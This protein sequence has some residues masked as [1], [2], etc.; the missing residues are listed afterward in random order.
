MARL[1]RRV[2]GED[3]A[4]AGLLQGVLQCKPV[5]IDVAANDSSPVDSDPWGWKWIAADTTYKLGNGTNP[6]SGT[7]CVMD[8]NVELSGD[9]GAD[10]APLD[11]SV[12]ATG[13]VQLTGGAFIS[14]TQEDGIAIL[15]GGDLELSGTSGVSSDNFEG[16]IYVNS[17]CDVSGSATVKGQMICVDNPNPAGSR[18][19]DPFQNEFSGSISVSFDCTG[20]S[21]ITTE[22]IGP[23]GTGGWSQVVN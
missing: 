3:R 18:D 11:M 9:I 5:F 13:S 7:L 22:T 6:Q 21:F 8:N 1:H 10:G 2:S 20:H 19:L 4:P 15:A 16:L 17:Q 14:A 23:L 12:I